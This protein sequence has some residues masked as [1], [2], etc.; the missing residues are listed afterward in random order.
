MQPINYRILHLLVSLAAALPLVTPAQ[1]KDKPNSRLPIKV[2]NG[3][4]H[5]FRA[6]VK[7]GRF[8][9]LVAEGD[10]KA[11]Y[12]AKCAKAASSDFDVG[13][14]A[15]GSLNLTKGDVFDSKNLVS[16]SM[17]MG[18]EKFCSTHEITI[19]NEGPGVLGV[20]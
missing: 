19:Q 10:L 5:T 13:G 8:P 2:G 20:R 16:N 18:M 3:E 14:G 9:R 6:Q 7:G 1:T 17:T 15:N 12:Q 11:S 4:S